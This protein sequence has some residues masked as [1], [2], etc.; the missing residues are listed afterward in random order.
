MKI[1]TNII[2]GLLTLLIVSSLLLINIL[3]QPNNGI[4]TD[5]H[6]E[7][8]KDFV[9]DFV[10]VANNDT[11]NEFS[12]ITA[13][14]GI[15]KL[16]I[17]HNDNTS[18]HLINDFTKNIF[19]GGVGKDG[20]PP[21]DNPKFKTVAD[22]DDNLLKD[23]DIVFGI[24]YNGYVAAYPQKIL[25]W[26][27]IVNY[28]INGKLVSITYCPL[29]GSTI[30]YNGQI[31]DFNTTLGVSGKL[32]NSNLLMY[33]R[34]T[35]S[36]WPQI[37][38]K[39]I[40]DPYQGKKLDNIQLYWSTWKQWKTVYPDTLVLDFDTGFIRSY[41]SDPYGSYEPGEN[42]SYYQSGEPFFGTMARFTIL[43][44][45]EVVYGIQ[46]NDTYLAIQKRALQEVK[47][48]NYNISDKN[49]VIIYD[50]RLDSAFIYNREL[51][52]VTYSFGY[53]NGEIRDLETKS[54]WDIYGKSNNLGQLSQEVYMDVFWFGWYAFFPTTVLIFL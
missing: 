12:N 10:D 49:I 52:G 44:S 6:S 15:S 37:L 13:N 54:V 51:N 22:V 16:R 53:L 30:A 23:H 28:E 29:T 20:I 32:I 48:I 33:D 38:G 35:D 26:H 17:F 42:N 36:N 34:E 1:N 43:E 45:K 11:S 25:V 19:S 27:E 47:L 14:N 21:I 2:I 40:S 7:N 8:Y 41:N 4:D 31:S 5:G 9:N 3:N 39:G 18:A 24:N 46:Y 50:D